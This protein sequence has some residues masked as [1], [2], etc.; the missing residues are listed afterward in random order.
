MRLRANG[1][2]LVGGLAMTVVGAGLLVL[3]GDTA[4]RLPSILLGGA[5]LAWL[6]LAA[7]DLIWGG[8]RG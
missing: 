4:A 6:A 8:R 5:G 1:R 2:R 3:L 7:E